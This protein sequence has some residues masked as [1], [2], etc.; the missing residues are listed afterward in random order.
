[1]ERCRTF[2]L[3]RPCVHAGKT[4][5]VQ[6]ASPRAKPYPRQEAK[7]LLEERRG[8]RSRPASSADTDGP[9]QAR[10]ASSQVG[11]H[12]VLASKHQPGG[13]TPRGL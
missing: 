12:A 13:A 7:G 11:W 10:R 8:E 1:M 9:R 4:L 3:T 6:P 5:C 2:F